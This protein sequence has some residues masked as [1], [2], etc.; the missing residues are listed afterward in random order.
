M[1]QEF[2]PLTQEELLAEAAQTE[3]ENTVSVQVARW[4]SPSQLCCQND[5]QDDPLI[6]RAGPAHWNFYCQTDLHVGLL[7]WPAKRYQQWGCKPEVC[8]SA[9]V[10]QALMAAEEE[11]KARAASRKAKYSG[12]M[13]RYHSKKQGGTSVVRPA[14]LCAFKKVVCVLH[15][16]LQTPP[17]GVPEAR[18]EGW[19]GQRLVMTHLA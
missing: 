15:Q 6:L 10:M 7:R 8:L 9:G 17:A 5:L 16:A 11:V 18:N 2:R 1:K 19:Q 3:I 13:L 12:P 14:C 4:L